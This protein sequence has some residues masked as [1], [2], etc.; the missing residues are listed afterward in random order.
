LNVSKITE[1]TIKIPVPPITKLD[2]PV[3]FDIKTG[4]TAM[5][6]KNTAPTLV[7]L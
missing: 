7:I 5:T 4:R 2:T 6:P 1:T 3:N